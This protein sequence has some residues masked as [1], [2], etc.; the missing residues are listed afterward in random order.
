MRLFYASL[1]LIVAAASCAGPAA[2]THFQRVDGEHIDLVLKAPAARKV[3]LAA[4][5][6]GFWPRAAHPRGMGLWVVR[7]PADR[8]FSYF[9]LI[10]GRPYKPACDLTERDDFGGSDCLFSPG[11]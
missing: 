4:S 11:P 5:L 6:D 10:D 8:E 9:Y 1:L 3:E 7:M 2:S